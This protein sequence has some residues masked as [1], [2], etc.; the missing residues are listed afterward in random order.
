MA[1]TLTSAT[2][3]L[4][5]RNDSLLMIRRHNTGY[6]DGKF[7][8]IAGHIEPPESARDA[9]RRE[10]NEEAGIDINVDDL[11]FVHVMHR[12]KADGTTKLDLFFRCT[13]WTGQVVN[14]EPHKCDQME[15]FPTARLP[16]DGVVPYVRTALNAIDQGQRFSEFGW[17][18][19][20]VYA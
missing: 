12:F 15:W 19:N 5:C 17:A 18:E 7:S 20:E 2:H 3:L 11:D 9:M 16:Y 14:A 4:I 10:A 1:T 8:I 6:E 13:R